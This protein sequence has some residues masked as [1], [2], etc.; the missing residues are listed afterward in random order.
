M[1]PMLAVVGITPWHWAAFIFCIVLF[2]ALDLGVFHHKAHV[3]KFREAL[4][5]T[6]VWFSTAMLFAYGL[7][8]WR[9]SEF[10]LL[11]ITGYILELSLSMDNVF[12]NGMIPTIDGSPVMLSEAITNTETAIS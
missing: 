8:K 1:P 10:A 3:V 6:V 7:Y 5:W 9:D 11:F 2:L 4:C 12:G